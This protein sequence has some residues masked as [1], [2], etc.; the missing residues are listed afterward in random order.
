[1]TTP[2]T[3]HTFAGVVRIV[4]GWRWECT[5]GASSAVIFRSPNSQTMREDHRLHANHERTGI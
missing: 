3:V 2:T 4:S 1:M 5:C